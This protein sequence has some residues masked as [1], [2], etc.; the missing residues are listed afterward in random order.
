MIDVEYGIIKDILE[1][2]TCHNAWFTQSILNWEKKSAD[3][4]STDSFSFDTCN[5]ALYLEA[6]ISRGK[7]NARCVGNGCL[8]LV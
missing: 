6:I 3:V 4:I 1:K 5:S 7:A 2:V 8:A